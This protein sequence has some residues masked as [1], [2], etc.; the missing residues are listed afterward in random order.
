MHA[1]K[2]LLKYLKPYKYIALLGPFLMVV[3]VT[4]DLIQPT[5]MQH[6]IDTGIANSDNKYVITLGLL[7]ILSAIIGLIGGVGCSIY[8]SRTAVHFATDIR[9]DLFQTITHFSSSNK[10]SFGTGKLITI[11][12]SDVETLQRALMMTLKVFV[13]GPLLFIGSIIVVYFTARQLFSIL[14][15]VVPILIVCMYFFTKISGA[16]FQKVQ[17]AI[18]A[19]NTKLQ[20]N[21]AGIRV[22]KAFNRKNH[23][24]NQFTEVNS[25][26]TAKNIRADQI[27]GILMP[28][29]LFVTNMGIVAALWMG[30]IKVDNGTMQVGVIL[31]FIN[32]LTIIMNGL[33]SSSNVLVQIARA[34]PSANRI[35]QVLQTNIDVQNKEE[36]YKPS[37]IKGAVQFKDVSYSYSKNGEQVLKNISFSISPG[38]TIGI[39][40]TTGSGKS[41]LV[42]LIPR[43]F[44]CDKGE[45]EIDGISIKDYNLET[46]RN[47]IGFTPQKATLFSGSIEHNVKYGKDDASSEELVAA[48]EDSCASEFVTRFSDGSNHELTQG[49]TNLSGGQR[50]RLAMARAFVRKPAI[51]ILDDS[52]SAVDSISENIIQKA[53]YS[54]YKTSTIFIVAS[55]I[56]SIKDADQ[57]LVLE[58]GEIVGKGTHNQLLA[59]NPIYQEIY[60]TQVGKEGM[61]VESASKA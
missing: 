22:I 43:L 45:I 60:S 61:T 56:S 9:Q 14:L 58:D 4:M 41:T 38:E 16:L 57:I 48:L 33:I 13:R 2:Q 19:V 37:I 30:V 21:L 31:A 11:M 6:I 39:I 17:E 10:D 36:V 7:M 46:L 24:I 20:E 25:H 47:A 29:T 8:S 35:H 27:V 26:L 54:E 50:Q 59:N 42:K 52:T 18:D 34:F 28:L 40:G 32:Y 55:K 51:L 15:F 44:D 1:V 3:E 53:I 12:T 49:A 23:Q 5:I